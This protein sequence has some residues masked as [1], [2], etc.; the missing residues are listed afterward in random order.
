M[1]TPNDT[2]DTKGYGN[3]YVNGNN[4]IESNSLVYLRAQILG[5]LPL[6]FTVT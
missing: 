3:G 1:V 4:D 6:T 5:T 2:N